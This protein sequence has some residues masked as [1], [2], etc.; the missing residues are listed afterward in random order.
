MKAGVERKLPQIRKYAALVPLVKQNPEDS[1]QAFSYPGAPPGPVIASAAKQSPVS[2][3]GDCFVPSLLAMTY[4]EKSPAS[5]QRLGKLL[6]LAQSSPTGWG[7][8]KDRL[9]GEG[10]HPA[11]ISTISLVYQH[12]NIT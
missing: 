1:R 6:S 7:H 3:N 8:R 2:E 12:D 11:G 4:S 5:T 10:L 9:V